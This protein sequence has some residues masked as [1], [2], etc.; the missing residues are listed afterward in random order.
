MNAYIKAGSMARKPDLK[1]NINT[2]LVYFLLHF[3]P[4][5]VFF[6]YFL[7]PIS[8]VE[9]RICHLCWLFPSKVLYHAIPK[10]KMYSYL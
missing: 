7:V 10:P 2:G 4:F 1:L 6:F 9:T 5:A 8:T 3:F